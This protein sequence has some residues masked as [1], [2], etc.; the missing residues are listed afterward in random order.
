VVFT[1]RF[2]GGRQINEGICLKCAYQTGL[3]GI[4]DML[5]GAGI[6]DGNVDEIT[7]RLNQAMSGLENSRPDELFRA[8]I[9]Q[10]DP[11]HQDTGSNLFCLPCGS[12]TARRPTRKKEKRSKTKD[13]ARFVAN[14][15][16][17]LS[18]ENPIRP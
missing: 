1:T 7:E 17:L 9:Q 3:G 8:V 4:G 10:L 5:S 2:E 15:C 18:E 14:S 11:E 13:T 12:R 6:N 16:R